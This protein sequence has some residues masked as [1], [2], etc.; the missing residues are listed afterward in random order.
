M[1]TEETRS[2]DVLNSS[3]C[4]DETEKVYALPTLPI[5]VSADSVMHT[6]PRV[7]LTLQQNANNKM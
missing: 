5:Y 3:F 7:F 2:R 6:T 1:N 4:E